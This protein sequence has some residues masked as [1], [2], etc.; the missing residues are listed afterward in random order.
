[1]RAELTLTNSEIES[2]ANTVLNKFEKQIL[3]SAISKINNN[4][5]DLRS[6][7]MNKWDS[8]LEDI[9]LQLMLILNNNLDKIKKDIQQLVREEVKCQ[10]KQ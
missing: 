6:E 5:A 7:M 3:K 2:I 1:M 10:L 8:K 9:D 4:I